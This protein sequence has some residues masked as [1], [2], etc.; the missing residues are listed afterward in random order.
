MKTFFELREE[1]DEGIIS[2]IGKAVK[3]VASPITNRLTRSGRAA[4]AQK[5]IDKHDRKQDQKNTLSTAKSK[6]IRSFGLTQKS[7]AANAQK[8]L[9]RR[10]KIQK[11]KDTI[12]R[13]RSLK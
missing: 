10:D 6:G 11:Q 13:A 3:K 2:G 5:K 4:I 8:K 1:L 9:D 12:A 7:R